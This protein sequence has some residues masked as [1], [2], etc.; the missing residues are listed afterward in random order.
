MVVVTH[1]GRWENLSEEFFLSR[2]IVQNIY[3]STGW[4]ELV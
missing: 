3:S 2:Q 4:V 1:G